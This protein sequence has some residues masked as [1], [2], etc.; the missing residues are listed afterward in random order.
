MTCTA[1][2]ET[3]NSKCIDKQPCMFTSNTDFIHSC[4]GVGNDPRGEARVF[5]PVKQAVDYDT[6][7]NYVRTWVPELRDAGRVEKE[8]DGGVSLEDSQKHFAAGDDSL[9]NLM[10][11]FQAWRLAAEEKKRLGIEGEDWVEHPLIKI[12]FSINRRGGGAKRGQRGGG[13]GFRGRGR[14][15][16]GG[17]GRDQGKEAKSSTAEKA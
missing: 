14:G 1:T 3:G 2:G 13:G 11:V 10:G 12:D 16:K 7:G 9:E 4:G 17:K 8:G 6:N 5:N 15:G